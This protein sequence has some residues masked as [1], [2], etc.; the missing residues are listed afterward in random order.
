[1]KNLATK[2][3]MYLLAAGIINISSQLQA[4]NVGINSTGSAPN[5]SAGLDVDFTNK[6]LLIPRVSLTGPTD[7]TTIS[8][9][10]T[11]L[12]VYNTASAG[13]LTPGY[14]YNAGTPA[15][16]NWVRL[17]NGG[18]PGTA[19][20]LNGNAGTTAGT[21]FLGTT[22]NVDLVFKTNNT[23]RMRITNTG[24][25]GIGTTS[26]ATKLH[27]IGGGYIETGATTS[28]ID[29]FI[30]RSNNLVADQGGLY[31]TNAVNFI[32]ASSSAEAFK[33]V[34]NNTGVGSSQIKMGWVKGNAPNT[35]LG[36]RTINID[37]DLKTTW[38][39]NQQI[40][41]NAF[42]LINGNGTTGSHDFFTLYDTLNPT[43]NATIAMSF[44]NAGRTVYRLYLGGQGG[45]FGVQPDSWEIWEYPN[46][47]GSCCRQRFRIQN[48]FSSSSFPY[49]PVTISPTNELWAYAFNVLSDE[50][51]KTNIK[52]YQNNALNEVMKIK[53]YE[54]D[55]KNIPNDKRIG[56]L[57]N[58]IKEVVP[59]IVKEIKISEKISENE[60]NYDKIVSGVD[61]GQLT[62]ILTKAIQEQQKEIANLKITNQQL[63]QQNELLL[64][65]LQAIKEKLG[66][67]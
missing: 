38:R 18:T 66:L 14:Y 13:G 43:G 19:W 65:E 50:Q 61:Y 58:E 1:M 30:V 53:V 37:N 5:N 47:V 49:N 42:F 39:W 41:S 12:L 9:P 33:F 40:N 20:L 7:N 26:P 28:V 8:N 15:S 44:I 29:G 17:L 31:L 25:V 22:D 35:F 4:Q 64:K 27:L 32:T 57:A 48:S 52:E 67:K 23:E 21:H 55:Y 34:T 3:G 59:H 24:N 16:P 2:I 54:Y 60:Y 51:L 10:A 56:F 11:S 46:I 36:R 63:Q 45:F 62:P 6:G